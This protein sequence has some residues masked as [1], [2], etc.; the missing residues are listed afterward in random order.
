MGR[1][2]SPLHPT[3]RELRS[4]GT[5]AASY[6][7]SEASSRELSWGTD[8]ILA[9]A[10]GNRTLHLLRGGDDVTVAYGAEVMATRFS[11]D[12]KRLAVAV[13]PTVMVA[14]LDL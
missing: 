6:A 5:L 11:P 12:G 2:R 14:T 8:G 10:A 13:G 4:A 1:S 7:G 3:A 9:A